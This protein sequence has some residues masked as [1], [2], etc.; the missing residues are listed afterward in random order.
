MFKAGDTVTAAGSGKK[1]EVQ[2]GPFTEIGGDTAYL[3]RLL[4]GP[5][6][7]RSST[8]LESFLKRVPKFE[9]GDEVDCCGDRL[10][11][12][13]GPFRGTYY[14]FYVLENP[15]TGEHFVREEIELRP[16]LELDS[17]TLRLKDVEDFSGSN[18]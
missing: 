17:T 11:V 3:V 6:K 15:Q 12:F 9:V 7:G 16:V 18:F 13:A 2:F 4:E 10:K 14:L 8:V 1:A 5:F